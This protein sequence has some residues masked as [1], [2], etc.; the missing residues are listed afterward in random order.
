[1]NKASEAAA[2]Y[3]DPL[4]WLPRKP[5][6]Q[7]IRKRVIYDT[8]HNA[9]SLYVVVA[10]RVKITQTALDGSQTVV[11]IVSPDGF[12][13]EKALVGAA[14]RAETAVAL[15]SVK[16]M[17]WSIAEIEQQIEREPGLGIALVQFMVRQCLLLE[18]RIQ[19]MAV[20]KTP[21]R[22]ALAMVQLSELL[23]TKMDDG[24][25]R[26]GGL[27]HHTLAEYVGTSREI[28][29]YQLNRLRRLGLLKYSRKNIDVHTREILQSFSEAGV[30]GDRQGPKRVVAAG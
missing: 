19:F 2:A 13:G 12:F 22:V 14:K 23:G 30:I 9:D 4:V 8:Q 28:V 25:M 26:M 21:E 16:T 20:C 15:D 17:A 18:D 3:D 10:G 1:M 5:V 11:R 24:A 29:T 7:F 27:T 6:Q